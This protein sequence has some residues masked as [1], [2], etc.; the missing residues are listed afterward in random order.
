MRGTK[1]PSLYTDWG[2][3]GCEVNYHEDDTCI[4]EKYYKPHSVPNV[5]S[6]QQFA[7]EHITT[8][9]TKWCKRFP[10]LA[11]YHTYKN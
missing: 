10:L 11:S 6:V 9:D 4:L 1:C 5:I 2:R 8:D 7:P 3:V